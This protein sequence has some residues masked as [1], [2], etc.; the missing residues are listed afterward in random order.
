MLGVSELLTLLP[1]DFLTVAN[2]SCV[3]L[4]HFEKKEKNCVQFV[5]WFITI[6]FNFDEKTR[7]S[8]RIQSFLLQ[9]IGHLAYK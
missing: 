9:T 5:L 6:C 4:L 2:K 8:E 7:S 1:R 3:I